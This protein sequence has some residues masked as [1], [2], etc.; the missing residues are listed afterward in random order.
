MK[1]KKLQ[2]ANDHLNADYFGTIQLRIILGRAAKDPKLAKKVEIS[3]QEAINLVVV[4]GRLAKLSVTSLGLARAY[5]TGLA[6]GLSMTTLRVFGIVISAALIPFDMYHLITSSIKMHSK[7]KSK[8]IKDVESLA[9]EL[10]D[11]L[12]HLLKDKQHIIVELKRFDDNQ[13]QHTLLLARPNES[14]DDEDNITYEDA[15]KNHIILLDEVSDKKKQV[16]ERLKVKWD[17]TCG[18]RDLQHII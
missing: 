9:D 1:N 3:S 2:G 15:V 5:V 14:K 16:F 11:G 10:E 13:K 8:V 17:Q 18:L 6:S 7:E 12:F 4:F